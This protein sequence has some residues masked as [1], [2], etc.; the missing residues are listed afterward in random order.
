MSISCIGRLV[1]VAG[2]KD[3]RGKKEWPDVPEKRIQ[4]QKQEKLQC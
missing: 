1:E 4:S 3:K 2:N